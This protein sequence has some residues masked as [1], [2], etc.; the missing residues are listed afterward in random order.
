M[1]KDEAELRSLVARLHRDYTTNSRFFATHQLPEY[2]VVDEL[3][4]TEHQEALFLTLS[5]VPFHAHPSGEPKPNLGRAGLWKV[6]ANIWRQHSWAYDP[7]ELVEVEGESEL[8]EFFDRLEIM[9]SYD[10][11]WWY[12][13]AETLLNDLDGDPRTLLTEQSYV[14]PYIARRVR[15]YDLPGIADDISTPFWLRLIHDRT[16]E[17]D[18]MRWLSMPVDHTIFAVTKQLGNLEIDIE[19]RED[20]RL[21]STY[22]A[23]FT[24]KHRI[25]PANIERPLRLVGLHW[26]DGGKAYVQKL[27]KARRDER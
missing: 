25:T 7:K 19:S 3:D 16:H 23:V 10:A 12:T 17:L 18:G 27:L 24:Q 15:R 22:W 2:D 6:C 21:V 20:R 5:V 13:S 14:A 1:I 8:E 26:N 9:D 4:L 11:H